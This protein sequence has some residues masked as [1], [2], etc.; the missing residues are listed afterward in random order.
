[1]GKLLTLTKRIVL[2]YLVKCGYS[3]DSVVF[4]R[5]SSIDFELPDGRFIV[6]KRLAGNTIYFTPKQW[7]NLCQ[8][9]DMV[10]DVE[11]FVVRE[12]LSEPVAIIPFSEIRRA[13]ETSSGVA[14]C[15]GFNVVAR[16][17]GKSRVLHIWCDEELYRVFKTFASSYRDYADALRELMVRA[18][19]LKRPHTF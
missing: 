13:V 6:V 7:D 4:N 16:R 8:Y 18:G 5:N 10:G 19:V 11:V 3:R 2:D 17:P 9:E 15:R 1:M 14:R 12:G